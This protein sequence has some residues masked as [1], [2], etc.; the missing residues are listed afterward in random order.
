MSSP[1]RASARTSPSRIARLL[2]GVV[3]LVVLASACRPMNGSETHLF[4]ETNAMRAGAGLP[5][6]AQHDA[7]T[8]EARSWAQ[9]LAAQGSLA[10]SDPHAWRVSW[11][12][13][14]ENVG[15]AGSIETVTSSLAASPSHRA[16]M[17]STKYSHMAIGTARGKDGRIYAVQLFW[18]G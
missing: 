2:V 17:L 14:A 3:M 15:T 16:N 11:R 5:A 8:D 18:R 6:L 1:P 9:R 4:R 7:L 13:V 10:H 12:A